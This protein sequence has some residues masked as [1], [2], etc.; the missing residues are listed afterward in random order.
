MSKYGLNKGKIRLKLGPG[1]LR[2]GLNWSKPGLNKSKT[3]ARIAATNKT[4]L[5]QK[6]IL[7][8]SK[9]FCQI[10]PSVKYHKNHQCS[11]FTHTTV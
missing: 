10:R 7:R 1:L 4:Q 6:Q 9:M 3:E 11:S 2:P 8:R 5:V